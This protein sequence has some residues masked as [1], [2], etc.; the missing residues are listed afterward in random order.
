MVKQEPFGVEQFMDKYETSIQFNMGETCVDSLRMKD[1]IPESEQAAATDALLGTKLVYGHIRGSPELKKEIAR[2]YGEGITADDVVITN[3]AIGANFLLFYSLVEKGGHVLVM[4]PSYQQLS[5]VPQMFG[6]DVDTFRVLLENDYLPDLAA[7]EKEIT[8]KKTKLLVI[9]NPNN[10]TGCV[11]ENDVME[12]IVELC[13][14]LDVTLMCDE[15]YRP[16]YHEAKDTK[17][18]VCYGYDKT[19]STGSMSKAFSLA[20]LRLGWIVTKNAELV[21]ALYE[22][23]DYNTISVL[24]VDDMLAT[25]A[26]QNKERIL[27]RGH[28]ICLRNLDAIERAIDGLNGMLQWKRPRGGSTCFVKINASINT[29]EMATELATQHGVLLVPGELFNEPGSVRIGFGNSER[30]IEEGL[31]I[32][33]QWLTNN[34]SK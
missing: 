10:P 8:E 34:T 20:G 32:L 15:V 24:M 1:I 23:R 2:L 11:W 16:L 30:D 26:L 33:L 25:L 6:G 22:K 27:E 19:V 4:E 18:V 3:G 9:N 5:S 7:L 17:S 13:R 21:E 14:K 28:R 12:R 31:K 29:L